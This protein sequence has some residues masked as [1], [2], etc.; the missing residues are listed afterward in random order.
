MGTRLGWEAKGMSLTRRQFIIAVSGAPGVWLLSPPRG[1][2]ATWRRGT[3]APTRRSEVAAAALGGK[4]YVVGGFGG[5][6][7]GLT[8][9]Y[10][11]VADRWE[12]RAALP[13]GLHHTAVVGLDN[14]LFVVGGY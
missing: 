14:R 4:I 7:G 11:P 13:V 8:E 9:A 10:D 6:T 2:A 12:R 5:G 1:S 3:D